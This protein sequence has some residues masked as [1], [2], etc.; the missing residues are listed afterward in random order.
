MISMILV[1]HST[2]SNKTGRAVACL[3]KTM[4]WNSVWN[5]DIA[6]VRF[7]T[8]TENLSSDF[9]GVRY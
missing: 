3:T 1:L 9:G 6:N 2:G 7:A 5:G 8:I 4:A